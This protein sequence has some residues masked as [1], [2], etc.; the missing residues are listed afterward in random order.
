MG[1]GENEAGAQGQQQA[2]RREP[3]IQVATPEIGEVGSARESVPP[4][5]LRR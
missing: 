5:E 2:V 3:Y 1:G 4:G